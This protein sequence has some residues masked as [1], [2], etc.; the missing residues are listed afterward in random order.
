[1]VKVDPE[2]IA[3]REAIMA[4]HTFI[5]EMPKGGFPILPEIAREARRLEEKAAFMREMRQSV[6]RSRERERRC[7]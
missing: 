3:E 4:E 5:G 1:M 2:I 7:E 6:A